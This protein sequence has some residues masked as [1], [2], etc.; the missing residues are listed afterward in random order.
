M[1]HLG[2]NGINGDS[3]CAVLSQIQR[4]VEF[5]VRNIFAYDICVV[6]DDLQCPPVV[7]HAAA[8]RGQ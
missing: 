3:K 1:R 8:S 6:N 2:Q 5:W 7:I 4:T